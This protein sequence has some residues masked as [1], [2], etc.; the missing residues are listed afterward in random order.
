MSLTT[1]QLRSYH[2]STFICCIVGQKQLH[3]D[4]AISIMHNLFVKMY[5]AKHKNTSRNCASEKY[6]LQQTL[7][8]TFSVRCINCFWTF[9][10][11]SHKMK[12]LVILGHSWSPFFPLTCLYGNKCTFVCLCV[13]FWSIFLRKN[14]LQITPANHMTMS[15]SGQIWSWPDYCKTKENVNITLLDLCLFTFYSVHANEPTWH[16]L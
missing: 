13:A 8:V 3:A 16:W 5:M 10:T 1:T 14:S 15:S 6:S 9:H 7:T 12:T 11:I 4:Q 2:H